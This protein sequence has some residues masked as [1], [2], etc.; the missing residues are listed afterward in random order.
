MQGNF[1]FFLFIHVLILAKV[2]LSGQTQP[3]EFYQLNKSKGLSSQNFNLHIF[4]DARGLIWISSLN[5]LNR[6]DGKEITTYVHD[7]N[8]PNSLADNHIYSDFFED[9]SS[10]IWFST[11][12]AVHRY[13]RKWDNFT[14]FNLD[15]VA[16]DGVKELRLIYFDLKRKTLW[17]SN[18]DKLYLINANAIKEIK[19]VGIF[20]FSFYSNI[21]HTNNRDR[22]YLFLPT[23][24][25]FEYVK[26]SPQGNILSRE[27][28]NLPTSKTIGVNSFY[29]EHDSS[30]WIGTTNGLYHWNQLTYTFERQNK[31]YA[32]YEGFNIH[33]LQLF[34][35]NTLIISTGGNGINLFDIRKFQ[36][37]GQLFQQTAIGVSPFDVEIWKI[38]LDQHA[39]LWMSSYSGDGV[40]LINLKK[41][42]FFIS[43]PF[44][45]DIKSKSNFIHAIS[46]Q[47]VFSNQ[48]Q[49]LSRDGMY[50]WNTLDLSWK[51]NI[52]FDEAITHEYNY[53]VFTDSQNRIW[54]CNNTG[55]YMAEGAYR[56]FSRIEKKLSVEKEG[57]TYVYELSDKKLIASS[58]NLGL[59]EIK[60][61]STNKLVLFPLEITPTHKSFGKIYEDSNGNIY[62]SS[63]GNVIYI[64]RQG[65]NRFTL[66]DSITFPS[67]PQINSFIEDKKRKRLW[68]G[69]SYGLFYLKDNKFDELFKEEKLKNIDIKGMA[70]DGE[71]NLWL[72]TNLGVVRFIPESQEGLTYY[73]NSDGLYNVEFNH[74]S[75]FSKDS[76]VFFGSTNGVIF[77]NPFEVKEF[78]FSAKPIITKIG[79][80]SGEAYQGQ[81]KCKL[82]GATNISEI[83]HLELPFKERTLSFTFAPLEYSAP[84]EN[85]YKFFMEGVDKQPVLSGTNNSTRYTNL[86]IGT[87]TFEVDASNSDGVFSKNPR[88][89]TITILPPWYLTT[90]ALIFWILTGLCIIYGII[91]IR[92]S[93]LNREKQLAESETAVLRLQMNPHFI[94][95]SLN[96]IRSYIFNKDIQSADTYLEQF[97]ILIRG[98]LDS[99]EKS[100]STLFEEKEL[101]EHY[102]NAE[103]MRFERVFEFDFFIDS[104]LDPDEILIPTLIIQPFVEN[105]IWHGLFPKKEKGKIQVNVV[106]SEGGLVISIQDN[107]VGREYH[108]KKP[109]SH[110]SKALSITERRLDLLSKLNSFPSSI[111]ILDLSNPSGHPVGT[112]VIIRLPLL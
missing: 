77:F 51:R 40:F 22:I 17:L 3:H 82:T 71:K 95:N 112:E 16:I 30:I 50:S 44:P 98:I 29:Y 43:M 9:D 68:I 65:D 26:F 11:L 75:Y 105:A 90:L 76:L 49:V 81:L 58:K 14:R 2:D 12:K 23:E 85:T 108:R 38:H 103:K 66:Q 21:Y 20:N 33:D 86:P 1:L 87:H 13:N 42:K 100:F 69:S 57:I 41:K 106:E 84:G 107:G 83:Q 91:Q 10:N 79:T 54:I 36:H 32:R 45:E 62:L 27:F 53:Y 88:K 73:K 5:G 93:R 89:L 18:M 35:E 47:K 55:L 28:V 67:L 31:K 34:E 25:G 109:R 4:K 99:S 8:D 6:Y 92:L 78:P 7:S 56:P 70:Y 24:N 110:T 46:S 94:F 59:F 37:I 104:S 96:S 80:T 64:Y 63:D 97:A 72:S 52:G 102:V 60:A 48:L 19:F 15:T 111:K 101:I 39:N 61:D 74:W